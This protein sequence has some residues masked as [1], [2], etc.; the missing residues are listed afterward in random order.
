MAKW[1]F[2]KWDFCRWDFCLGGIFD[3]WDFGRWDFCQVGI[4]QVG[5]L[6]GGILVSGIF[7]VGFWKWD[8]CKWDLVT[9]ALLRTHYSSHCTIF[10]KS[11][12]LWLLLLHSH[13]KRRA[14]IWIGCHVCLLVK[15]S[16]RERILKS[17]DSISII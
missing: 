4:S 16:M 6:L 12:P 3:R 5:F 11:S 10:S 1:D 2:C 15:S 14:I 9:E 17:T 7:V 13:I 8:F